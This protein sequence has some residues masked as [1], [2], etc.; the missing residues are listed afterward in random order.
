M[1]STVEWWMVATFDS[2]VFIL[3]FRFFSWLPLFFYFSKTEVGDKTSIRFWMILVVV[4][5]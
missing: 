2:P 3:F 5:H 1:V 4:S